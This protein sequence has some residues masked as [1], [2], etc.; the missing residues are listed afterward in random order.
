MNSYFSTSL[1]V[2]VGFALLYYL[3]NCFTKESATLN[4]ACS[5]E[6]VKL[7]ELVLLEVLS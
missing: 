4:S 6:S 2:S 7:R 5:A 3:K 1:L